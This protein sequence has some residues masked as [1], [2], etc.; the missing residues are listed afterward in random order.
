[1][2]IRWMTCWSMMMKKW[3]ADMNMLEF[4]ADCFETCVMA[5]VGFALIALGVAVVFVLGAF[6]K[7]LFI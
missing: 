5:I 2:K 6:L 3:G 7:A 1:M 4:L